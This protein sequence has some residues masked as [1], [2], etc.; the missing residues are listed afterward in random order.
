MTDVAK[1]KDEEHSRYFVQFVLSIGK[2]ICPEIAETIKTI[3]KGEILLPENEDCY[4]EISL[5]LLGASLAV[6][7][8]YSQVMSADRGVDIEK[9]CEQSFQ[10]DYDLPFDSIAKIH[11]SLYDYQNEFKKSMGNN[12]N[13]FA[14]ISQIMLVRCLG[15]KSP[16][17]FVDSSN[18]HPAILEAVVNIMML[19]VTKT[20]SFW[21]ER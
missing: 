20:L 6:L 4:F 1:N 18:F 17:L 5:C 7:K 16:K 13:P 21:E 3:S 9:Y 14:G 10:K 8:G 12:L 11:S 19:T 2:T 15:K